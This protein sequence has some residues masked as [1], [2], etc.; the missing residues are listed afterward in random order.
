MQLENIKHS[1]SHILA[2]AV[3]D[4]YPDVKFGIGPA[5]ENGFY[6]DMEVE[7]KEE[8]LEKIEKR[9]KEI[10]K[11]NIPFEKEEISKDEARKLFKDQPY[12][13]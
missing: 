5:I 4:L 3:N 9:M 12:K 2:H 7:L 1:L 6:Y 8:D 11:S 10:I 13:L